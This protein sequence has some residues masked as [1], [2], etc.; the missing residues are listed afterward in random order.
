MRTI[1]L[2]ATFALIL[3]VM[4]NG[5]KNDNFEEVVGVCPEVILTV[6]A[7]RAVDVPLNQI[8]TAN[9]NTRMN[10]TTINGT[11]FLVH[12]GTTQISGTVT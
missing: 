12:S 6:P 10:P 11:T 8:I 7:N 2:L 9:F 5:C 3:V 4:F 1:N